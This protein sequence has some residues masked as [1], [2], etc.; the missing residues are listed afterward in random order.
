M[1]EKTSRLSTY[2][3]WTTPK[4]S[5]VQVEGTYLP[6][7]G[8]FIYL[9]STVWHTEE[10]A[11]TSRTV[12]AKP[13]THLVCW[14]M[15]ESPHIIE[16]TLNWDCTRAASFPPYF[17]ALNVREWQRTTLETIIMRRRWIHWTRHP[18]GTRCHRLG[19]PLLDT[20]GETKERKTQVPTGKFNRKTQWTVEAELK[21]LN[22]TWDIIQKLAQNR[23]QWQTFVVALHATEHKGETKLK[24][25]KILLTNCKRCSQM[26][27]LIFQFA[28]SNYKYASIFQAYLTWIQPA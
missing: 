22:Y 25:F 18:E 5:P 2:A 10:Q 26:S 23:Q 7:T 14:T 6:T 9:G 24:R 4:P 19:H 28:Y 20:R 1:Q 16:P 21:A 17:M 27:G 15:C 12:S 8:E 11:V 3:H 13:E